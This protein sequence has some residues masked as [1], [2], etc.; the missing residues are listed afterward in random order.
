MVKAMFHLHAK[1]PAINS[2]TFAALDKAIEALRRMP[3]EEY[4]A[5]PDNA[6][7]VAMLKQLQEQIASALEHLR[8]E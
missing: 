2:R 8:I 1:N 5:I 4:E 3:R 6:A 7:Q